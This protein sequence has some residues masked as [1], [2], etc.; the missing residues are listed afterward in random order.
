VP[1]NEEVAEMSGFGIPN[2][3]I[4]PEEAHRRM[5]DEGMLLIDVREDYEWDAGHVP[6]SRHIEM[7][8]ISSALNEIPSDRPVGFLCLSG[9]RSGMV[10]Q[11]LK[12]AGYDAYNVSGGFG[13]WFAKRLPTEPD[14]ATVAPH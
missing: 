10:A 9:A 4:T 3:D 13:E 7:E 1:K 2:L 12:S 6:G 8:T 11:A 5:R 14:D